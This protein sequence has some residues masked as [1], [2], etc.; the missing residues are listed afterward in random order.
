VKI[1]VPAWA[2]PVTVKSASAQSGWVVLPAREW[3]NSDR[4]AV[5]FSLAP[6]LV[7][8]EHGNAGRAALAWGPFVLA[9]DQKQNPSLPAP[10]ALG[11][12]GSKP[13]FTLK[14]GDELAFS[15]KVVGRTTSEPKP[16]TLVTFADAGSDGGVYRVWLRAPGVA[17][18]TN[19]SLLAEGE[20]S[21]SR[22]GNQHG[23][24][25]DSDFESFAVTYDGKPAKE[26]WFAVTLAAPA[27]VRRIVF[28]H[29]KNFHDGGWFD[30]SAAKPHVQIQR[31]K[32]GPWE[33]VGE[34]ADYPATT[35]TDNKKLKPGQM[36]MLRLP[37]PVKAIT[38]RVIGK[39]ACGNK[40]TQAFSS[41]A[42]LQAFAN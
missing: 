21:R 25:N 6:R 20:E 30:A 32:G 12:I 11:L 40:P 15:A 42:E 33:T 28:A 10:T 19:D 31:G 29:G 39:P 34:L 2:T 35:A 9:C 5:K 13:P 26:D 18:A 36:F 8:G 16:A 23:Q 4:I 1:R 27:N 41:C 24:I 37:E 38:V 7:T 3:K 17:V 22:Q 14:P